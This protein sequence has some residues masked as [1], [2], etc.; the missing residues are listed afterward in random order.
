MVG[1]NCR[2]HNW[3]ETQVNMWVYEEQV[4]FRG[5]KRNLSEVINEQHENIKYLKGIELPHNIVAV[6]DLESACAGATLLIFGKFL[7]YSRHIQE[8]NTKGFV[9]AFQVG[10]NPNT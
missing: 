9:Y 4:D 7:F 3:C 1:R 5:Q 8:L 2:L 6:P 10:Y